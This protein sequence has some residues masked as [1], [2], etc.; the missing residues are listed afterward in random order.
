VRRTESEVLCQFPELTWVRRRC[1]L[2]YKTIEVME[3]ETY[4][5][6]Y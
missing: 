1:G 5:E 3:P 4:T 6:D 2:I